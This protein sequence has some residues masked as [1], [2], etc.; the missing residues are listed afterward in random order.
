M[1]PVE[2]L[3][4]S[5][6]FDAHSVPVD[7]QCKVLSLMDGAPKLTTSDTRPKGRQVL[8]PTQPVRDGHQQRLG[9]RACTYRGV[10]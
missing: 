9:A 10:M 6:G 5:F 4:R 1:K 7:R 2:A 3:P 8:L